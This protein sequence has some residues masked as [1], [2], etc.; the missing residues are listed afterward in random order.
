[1]FSGFKDWLLGRIHDYQSVGSK[2]AGQVYYDESKPT[3][4]TAIVK[5]PRVGP[6]ALLD[7]SK[8]V[9]SPTKEEEE[10]NVQLVYNIL[11]QLDEVVWAVPNTLNYVVTKILTGLTEQDICLLLAQT[12]DPKMVQLI[13]DCRLQNQ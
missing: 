5:M 7:T 8:R 3:N 13:L 11:T 10:K 9:S 4:R 6:V 12:K 1:M 2:M